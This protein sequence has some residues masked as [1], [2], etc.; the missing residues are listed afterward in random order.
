M[1]LIS[2]EREQEYTDGVIVTL[3]VKKQATAKELGLTPT[4]ASRLEAIGLLRRVDVE[5][6]GRRGRPA[7]VW[8][9]AAKARDRARRRVRA[10]R[11]LVAA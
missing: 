4:E 9:C 7:V 6:T 5:H 3:Y 1:G 11:H 2:E 8:T 10:G